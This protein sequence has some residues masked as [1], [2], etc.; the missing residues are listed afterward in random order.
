MPRHCGHEVALYNFCR[1]CGALPP[2]NAALPTNKWAPSGVIRAPGLRPYGAKTG[3]L[4][5]PRA[6]G[7]SRDRRFPVRT[8][9]RDAYI[10]SD[11]SLP[12]DSTT[13]ETPVVVAAPACPAPPACGM[14]FYVDPRCAGIVVAQWRFGGL[15][16]DA[17]AVVAY[18]RP[19]S[20]KTS[21]SRI[22]SGMA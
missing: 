2:S 3:I 4:G 19:I 15:R 18:D 8:A 5:A 11:R 9:S 7:S 12:R 21:V 16:V 20:R 13:I 17:F 22:A 14:R 1:P 6:R 10:P